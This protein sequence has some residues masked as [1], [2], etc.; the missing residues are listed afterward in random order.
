MKGDSQQA[1]FSAGRDATGNI[2]ENRS[3]WGGKIGDD[4]HAPSPLQN[5]KPIG[6]AWR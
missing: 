2:H 5:K 4:D 1:F 3:S 6:F